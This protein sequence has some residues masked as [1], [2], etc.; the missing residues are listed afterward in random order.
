[1]IN[2]VVYPFSIPAS[3]LFC[4]FFDCI[5]FIYLI[6]NYFVFLPVDNVINEQEYEVMM[7]IDCEVMD[8]R[9]LHVKSA[10]IPPFLREH[11]ENQTNSF[12]NSASSGS[13][14]AQVVSTI[15]E[16]PL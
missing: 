10:T 7:Q 8:T 14:H 16:S 9:I 4:N 15:T 12:Y 6:T 3:E 13:E 5:A 1:M 11:R 2:S